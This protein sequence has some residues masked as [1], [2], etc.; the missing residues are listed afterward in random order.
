MRKFKF[1]FVGIILIFCSLIFS[2]PSILNFNG[3]NIN[4]ANIILR[5][6]N[7]EPIKAEQV[8]FIINSQS[9][10]SNVFYT[11]T[12]ISFH[13]YINLNYKNNP[14]PTVKLMIESNYYNFYKT[15]SDSYR[16]DVKFDK[17]NDYNVAV[18]IDG[19]RVSMSKV[20]VEEYSGLLLNETDSQILTITIIS[21]FALLLITT[22]VILKVKANKIRSNKDKY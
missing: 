13:V 2:M 19:E 8:D 11:N 3:E 14:N 9:S 7:Y 5:A 21:L 22:F 20:I 17:A 12:T 15:N 4:N 6:Q 10:T 18:Y 1:Y 16:C